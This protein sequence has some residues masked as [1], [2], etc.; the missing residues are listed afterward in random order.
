VSDGDLVVVAL[1]GESFAGKANA[2]PAASVA[3]SISKL[4]DR[5]KAEA[6]SAASETA[7]GLHDHNTEFQLENCNSGGSSIEDLTYSND[8]T[9][10]TFCQSNKTSYQGT[11]YQL[12][13]GDTVHY[14]SIA[15][16]EVIR[17]N[18]EGE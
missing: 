5:S 11:A 8:H 15:P 18:E 4:V 1:G 14:F 16:G 13:N 17:W 9:Y 2:S 10:G 3:E 12:G 6:A 7:A